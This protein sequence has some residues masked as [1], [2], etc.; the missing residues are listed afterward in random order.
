MTQ[1][2]D[3]KWQQIADGMGMELTLEQCQVHWHHSLRHK[4]EREAE[5]WSPEEVCIVV[6]L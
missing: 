6:S 5:G 1:H 4:V 2:G 3:K